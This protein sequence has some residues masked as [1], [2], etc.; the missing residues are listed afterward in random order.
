MKK[1]KLYLWLFGINLFISAFTFG[2]GYIVVPMISKYFVRK[3]KLFSEEE[4][5]EMAAI[6]QSCPGAIAISLAG[7]AGKRA[8]GWPGVL[9]SCGAA[10]T[11][12]VVILGIISSWYDVFAANPIIAAVLRGMMA[13]VAALMIDLIINMYKLIRRENS[14]LLSVMA[15]AA[16]AAN[17]FLMVPAAILLFVCCAVCL[18]EIYLPSLWNRKH[19][20][21]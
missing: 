1:L 11:P 6:A 13:G 14:L 8:A 18:L 3:K 2:G 15:P 10:V 17:F 21:K 9:I 16:F 20:R 7:L 4:L 12:P 19:I 5:L